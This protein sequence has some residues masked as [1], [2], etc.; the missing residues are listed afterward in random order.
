TVPRPPAAGAAGPSRRSPR[1]AHRRAR[2]PLTATWS[3]LRES[4][5]DHVAGRLLTGPRQQRASRARLGGRRECSSTATVPRTRRCTTSPWGSTPSST[6]IDTPECRDGADRPAAGGPSESSS[7]SPRRD[8]TAPSVQV[9]DFGVSAVPSPDRRDAATG[10]TL[11][12]RN[13]L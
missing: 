12:L 13:A 3:Q 4:R 9:H 5:S 2:R 8:P 1:A 6:G 7:A 11:F 10:L